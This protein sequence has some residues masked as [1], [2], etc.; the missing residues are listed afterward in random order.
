M[1]GSIPEERMS[2]ESTIWTVVASAPYAWHKTIWSSPRDRAK[3]VL[4]LRS[5]N[6]VPT[7]GGTWNNS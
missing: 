2:V 3:N 7:E 4:A 5:L 6:V 1:S